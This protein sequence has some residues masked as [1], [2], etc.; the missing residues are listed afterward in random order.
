MAQDPNDRS[1]PVQVEDLLR[2]K[3]SERPTE[4]F[5]DEF[6]RGL[7]QRMLQ[8]LVKKDPWYR[9][10]MRMLTIPA[11]PTLAITSAAAL[12]L[13]LLLRP[14][15]FQAGSNV[16]AL[17]T[18]NPSTVRVIAPHFAPELA[19]HTHSDYQI[20]AMSSDWVPVETGFTCDFKFEGIQ[21]LRAGSDY[22][23]NFALN[24]ASL[25]GVGSAGLV[26]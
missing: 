13:L 17:A 3:R 8:A 5:W 16:S 20:E 18:H 6:D 26:F 11:L 23:M 22:S 12:A 24:A 4:A 9:Q 10:L 1:P 14:I 7:H 2:L 21:G 25:D 19:E 15:N